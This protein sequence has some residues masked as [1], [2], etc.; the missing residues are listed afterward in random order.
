MTDGTT[1]DRSPTELEDQA[2][3]DHGT[4]GKLTQTK[5]E[6]GSSSTS[7]QQKSVSS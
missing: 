1:T 7:V 5:P 4:A 6:I 2:S 3:L